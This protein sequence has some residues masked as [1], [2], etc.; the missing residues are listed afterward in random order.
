[1]KSDRDKVFD[2]YY[3]KYLKKIE[4]EVK[5]RCSERPMFTIH[6]SKK[7]KDMII[8]QLQQ[9]T[10]RTLLFEMKVC[11]YGEELVGTNGKEKYLDYIQR[12][13]CD[14]GYQGE[15]SE[16]YP[17]LE[18]CLNEYIR[19]ITENICNMMWRFETDKEFLNKTY[20]KDIPCQSIKMI[21]T[22]DS[23]RH[24]GNEMVY[25]LRLDNDKN[26]VY[27]PRSLAADVVFGKLID[28]IS[29][30]TGIRYWWNHNCDREDYGWSEWVS[31]QSCES[32]EQLSNYYIRIGMLLCVCYILGTTDIHY[33]NLISCGEYPI[34][35]DLETCAGNGGLLEHVPKELGVTRLYQESVLHSGILPANIMGKD[36]KRIDVSAIRG[37]SKPSLSL[38]T[39]PVIVNAGST[40]MHIDY[41]HL[42]VKKGKNLARL[43]GRFFKPEQFL[44]EIQHGFEMAYRYLM[45]HKAELQEYIIKFSDVPIRYLVRD[46][47]QYV[48]LLMASYNMEWMKNKES[49]RQFLY[50]NMLRGIKK[51]DAKALWVVKQETDALLRGDIPYF[52]Y[53]MKNTSL[54]A[55]KDAEYQNFFEKPVEVYLKERIFRMGEA[56]LQRQIKFID[57]S[58]KKIKESRKKKLKYYN[59]KQAISFVSESDI[60]EQIGE[61]ILKEAI[62]SE[63]G[64]DISWISHNVN[65]EGR[66]GQVQL[67][68]MYLYKGIAGVAIFMSLL[69]QKTD[70]EKYRICRDRLIHK[71]FRYTE[72]LYERICIDKDFSIKYKT[73]AFTGEASIAYSYQILYKITSDMQF[74]KMMEK[75]CQVLS[76]IIT[77]D[78]MY[79]VLEGNA[80]TIMVLLNAYELTKN[81][82]YINW[83]K[84]A[85]EWL[86][87]QVTKYENGMGWV[88]PLVGKALTGFAH[89]AS[90]IMMA[91]LRLSFVTREK[92]FADTAWEAYQYEESF[93]D[94]AYQDWQD[95]R[96]ERKLKKCI[97]SMAWCHGWGGIV[98]TRF[99]CAKYADVYIQDKAR[100]NEVL[101]WREKAK[102]ILKSHIDGYQSYKNCCL[103]HGLCGSLVMVSQINEDN[104]NAWKE[105]LI[106]CMTKNNKLNPEITEYRNMGFMN[107]MSGIGCVL[108]MPFRQ[109]AEILY[110]G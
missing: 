46:T 31:D 29:E 16:I 13:L 66:T 84:N 97:S 52:Y 95:L 102:R 70:K 30:G 27:K 75:H 93:F 47:Q 78:R 64:I 56:D 48:V 20:F 76:L 87:N 24:N 51:K 15:V 103:C 80:G 6:F 42:P 1:M 5:K 44:E 62:Y 110:I 9:I 14:H 23:D 54:Y 68:G 98:M 41:R 17:H 105:D 43:R 4:D 40:D 7:L 109:I 57:M 12:F 21:D 104:G 108:L 72:Q 33:E 77:G 50:E 22:G 53:N 96:G 61:L 32:D 63:D 90:G 3:R 18:E 82:Q 35:V 11:D 83:A 106:Q 45:N 79:D 36:G 25:I 94:S 8:K 86:L 74:L 81:E 19:C 71:L 100:Y 99:T 34:I 26:I 91:L 101:S 67:M 92:R 107:G 73:G 39:V 88:H 55:G 28:W 65:G 60:A 58:L 2:F 85:G 69:A 59:R 38:I 89:G 37:I 49:R 10:V